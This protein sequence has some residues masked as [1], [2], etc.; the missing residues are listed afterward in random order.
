M[1]TEL[2][3]VRIPAGSTVMVMF[4]AA[5]RDP[6]VFTQ[7]DRFDIER[8]NAGQHLAF[9]RGIHFCIGA[10]LARL[11]AR[12][13]VRALL[14]RLSQLR[15]DPDQP[16]VRRAPGFMVNLRGFRSLPLAFDPA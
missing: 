10:A 8:A 14:G 13:A 6:D 16:G 1:D 15:L 3:G 12:V 5:N 2:R 11:E 9:A 7:P 4:A